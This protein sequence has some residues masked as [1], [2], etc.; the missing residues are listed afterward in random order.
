MHEKLLIDAGLTQNEARVYLTLLE[1]G[2]SQSGKIVQKAK[3][4]GGKI[5]ETLSKLI[6]KGLVEVIVENGVKQFFA[7]DPQSI[8]MY[9]EEKKKKISEQTKSLAKIVPDLQK[10]REYEQ[11]TE[12]VYYIKGFKGIK[13]IVYKALENAKEVKIMGVRSS[14]SEKFNIFWKHWHNKRVSLKVKA[15]LLF[16]DRNT[17]YWKF[18]KKLKYTTIRSTPSLSPSAIMIIDNN[19]FIFSYDKELTTIHIASAAIAGSFN[20]FFDDLWEMGKE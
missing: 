10:I 2:K 17:Q 14:K 15:K 1:L 8:L 9:M 6:D 16:T 4:S 12:N 11:P 20:S 7:A 13:P 19:A 18:F 3:V 5:Y